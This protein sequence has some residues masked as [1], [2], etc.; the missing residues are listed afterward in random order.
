MMR[1]PLLLII[2]GA[3]APCFAGANRQTIGAATLEVLPPGSENKLQLADLI[4]ARLSIEGTPALDVFEFPSELPR[5]A[6]WG[7]V[8]VSKPVR[9]VAGPN[10]VT[11]QVAY[12]FGPRKTGKN[13]QFELPKIKFRDREDFEVTFAPVPFVVESKITNP[14]IADLKGVPTIEK[15]PPA[16]VKI[17]D[18]AWIWPLLACL[19]GIGA[20]IGSAVVVLLSRRS[21]PQS[22]VQLAL[23]EWQRLSDMK[24]P[25][26]GRGV[27]FITLLTALVRRHLERQYAIPARSRTT[28]EFIAFLRSHDKLTDA[29]R[30]FLA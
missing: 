10:R 17:P 29:Q 7:L 4:T 23:Y 12:Q 19:L 1:I 3:A 2:L 20:L 5:S 11:W 21:E 26:K 27:Q 9:K 8:E 16:P 24:L 28:P 22:P 30:D 13:V 15:L 6:A 14:G 18:W 25:E